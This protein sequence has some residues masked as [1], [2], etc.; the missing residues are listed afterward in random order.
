MIRPITALATAAV[1]LAALAGTASAAGVTFLD[2]QQSY[3]ILAHR[4][5]GTK[6][7]N[8]QAEEIG[9]VKDIIFNGQGT[10]TGVVIGVGGLLGI[11]EKLVAVPFASV[12]IGEV[13]Q[14]SRVVVLD[15][16]KDELKA[17]PAYSASEPATADR[18]KQKASD[19]LAVAK[20]KVI[21]LS[22][23]AA[24]KAKAATEK[25]KEM[26]APKDGAAPAPAPATKP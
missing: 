1:A 15:A 23:M 24:E 5:V 3:E 7:L 18:V 14:S 25:A 13:V 19:W 10:A 8:S 20:A 16:T 12:Q 9:D 22:K 17:A 26:A 4:L 6:V 21:E 2:K 11:P